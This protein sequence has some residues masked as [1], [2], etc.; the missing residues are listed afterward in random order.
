MALVEI[1][2]DSCCELGQVGGAFLVERRETAAG[3]GLSADECVER[4]ASQPE[5]TYI[6]SKVEVVGVVFA[7]RGE[8][9]GEFGGIVV[10]VCG[11]C[12][13]DGVVGSY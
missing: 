9:Q 3:V 2:G 4:E 8:P 7:L 5:I 6:V 1:G 12:P 11:C 13:G 10:L